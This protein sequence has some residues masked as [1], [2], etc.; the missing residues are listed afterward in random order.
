MARMR[1][2][3]ANGSLLVGATALALAAGEVLTRVVLPGGGP[4][5]AGPALYRHDDLLGW[6]KRPDVTVRMRT[7]EWD[8]TIA[9]NGRGM[10]GAPVTVETPG[11][12]VLLLGDS[13]VEG[14][15]VPEAET[16][17][18]ILQRELRRSGEPDAEVLNGGTAGYG[19]DQELLYYERDGAPLAPDITVLFFYHNDVWYN[20]RAH[21]WRGAKPRFEIADGGLSL[22]GVP[23]PRLSWASRKLSDGL[24]ERSALYRHLRTVVTLATSGR[25]VPAEGAS[26]TMAVPAELI[27]WRRSSDA[28]VERAWALTEA[29]LLRL[30]DRVEGRD[31]ASFAVF[32][33]PSKAAVYREV[34]QGTVRAY[35][36]GR[37]GWSPTADADRLED[38]CRRG[39]LTCL[40]PVERFRAETTP[41][42]SSG[43]LFFEVDGHW[44]AAGHAL[45]AT[46]LLEW[47]AGQG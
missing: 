39:G 19:T 18:A 24:T 16:V 30:R 35:G 25:P 36:L 4:A 1:N 42:G 6:E 23:V 34:W 29:L 27:A 13:F 43:A 37:A 17:A 41:L 45:A 14:Y 44:T 8:V 46:V 20:T 33:V 31:G 40:L 21:Y 22:R 26:S 15:T 12:R 47:L 10:R 5:G 7:A 38:I 3:L 32:Y 11:P 9:T 2:A 28:E